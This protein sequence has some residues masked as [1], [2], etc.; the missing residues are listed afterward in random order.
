MPRVCR[1]PPA[2]VR[3]VVTIAVCEDDA[4]AA[5][6]AGPVGEGRGPRR[7]GRPHRRRGAAAVPADVPRRGDPRHRPAGQR[8][9]RR[10]PRAAGRRPGR[11]GAVPDRPRRR[12]RQGR[13]LRVRR[14]RLPHQAVRAARAAGPDRRAGPAGRRGRR[15]ARGAAPRPGPA[16]R[17]R[18]RRDGPAHPDR[19]PA[20]GQA[21][22]HPRARRTTARAGR[23]GLADGGRRARQHAGLLHG[24]AAPQARRPRPGWTGPSTP[25]VAWATCGGEPRP[26]GTA[27]RDHGG[28]RA[29]RGHRARRRPP[30]AAR[31]P[32][33]ARLAVRPAGPRRRRRDDRPVHRWPG[34]GAGD[35]G[36]LPGPEH[37]DLRRRRPAGRRHRAAAPPA[38]PGR[39]AELVGR[40]AGR[41]RRRR[42]PAARPA[43]ATD[44]APGRSAPSSS[45]PS[46][47]R[48][49]SRPSAAAWWSASGSG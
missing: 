31:P 43:G 23:R 19:V 26:A 28:R 7:G 11:A 32:V 2:I 22:G 29:R 17:H 9:S 15:A 38:R 25:C 30:A 13:G 24:P 37:L 46:T 33:D 20:A 35:A 6:R 27:G 21:A 39:P 16:R 8:R 44:R 40:G 14:R 5:F 42:D 4:G 1:T 10:L 3:G 18:A 49:T 41:G 12:A 47:S 36:R 48:R 45:R 34:P